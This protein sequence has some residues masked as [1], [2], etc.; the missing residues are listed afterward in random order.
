VAAAARELRGELGGHGW[1]GALGELGRRGALG[2]LGGRWAGRSR[3]AL[4]A[5]AVVGAA[6]GVGNG[7][8]GRR[9]KQRTNEEEKGSRLS[10]L[11]RR[12][13]LW[14]RARCATRTSTSRR[15]AP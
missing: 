8:S 3:R 6:A 9:V 13:D 5:A 10:F 2:E 7:G 14:R 4:A 12:Q 11:A 1:R 15:S